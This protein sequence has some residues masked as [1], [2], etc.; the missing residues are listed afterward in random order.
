MKILHKISTL[1]RKQ[2]LDAEMSAEMRHH[3]DLQT[4]LNVAAGMDPDEARYRALR[5]FGNVPSVQE[6]VREERGWLW[7][8]QLWQ[9]VVYTGRTLAK[10]PG[11]AAVAVLTLALGIGVTTAMFSIIYGVLLEPYPYAKSAEIWAPQVVDAKTNRGVGLRV[12]DYLDMAKLPGVSSAMATS[13]DSGTL[14]GGLNPEI[15]TTVRVTGTAFEFLGVPPVV[16]RGLIPSDIRPNGEAEAV[17]VLSFKLWQR[18]YNSDP[19]CLGRTIVLD[20][21]PH[22]IVGVMPPRFGWY[23][24]DGLWRPLGTT[25]LQR[26]VNAIVRLK[27][28]V[29]REVAEE[30]LLGLMKEQAHENPGRF[31]KDGF[32]ARFSNYLDVTVSS[33]EMRTSLHLMFCAVGF[34]LLIAC[35]NVANLQLARGTSRSREMAVRLALGAGRGR[36]VRQLLTESVALSFVGGALGVLLAFGLVGVIV[37]LMPDFYVPN[38][39][40]VT[41]NGWV[42]LFSLGIAGLTGVLFGLVP[43]LQCT[44]PDLND[45]LKDGG[46]SAGSRRGNRTRN[47]LV[48]VEVAL[49]VVLLVGAS[50]AIRSFVK[51]QSV[52]R[53]FRTERMLLLRVPLVA[54][55]YTTIEQRNGFARDFLNRVRALPGVTHAMLGTPPGTEGSSGV[56]IAGQ[57]KPAENFGVNYI[58]AEY[59][60]T[61]GIPLKA[62]RNLTEQEIMRG[63]HVALVSEAAVKFWLNGESPLGRT[64]DVDALVG[65]GANNLAPEGAVKTVTVVGIIADTLT[66]NPRRPPPA[67]V[68]VPY[69]LRGNLNRIFVVRT[70]VEPS[71]L[72]NAIRTELQALDK[73]QPMQQPVTFEELIDQQFKQPRFNLALFSG[74]AGIALALAAAGIY[75]VLSYAVAQR[76][77]EIGVRMALGADRPNILALVFAAGG[78]LLGLGLVI[79]LAGSVAMTRVV[80]SKLF[81]GPSLDLLALTTATLLLSAVAVLACWIPALRAAKVNPLVALRAE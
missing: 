28:G 72:L 42:L 39:A 27:S 29:T 19:G 62:G 38:E 61:L 63:D 71:S 10:A 65:G 34:L 15:I 8:E 75:S 74:L 24:N 51:L 6:R 54:K 12:A 36:L 56:T 52:D 81:D 41:V 4:E 68:L 58:D 18:L 64:I 23:T 37:A 5:Q 31:P 17:A 70:A 47:V 69:T 49:S 67:A 59:L 77:R 9:D 66:S 14:S 35:T 57:P 7:L 73:E 46:H 20:D 43:G 2:K 22:V 25:D 40:R 76:T 45:A 21:Q 16:G 44:K 13:Y 78:R 48:L 11:F 1:F 55:R 50:L 32:S 60:A 33:G 3:V 26:G 79:G 53:G 80:N 30:Q